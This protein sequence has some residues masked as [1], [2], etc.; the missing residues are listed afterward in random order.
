M[1]LTELQVP[2]QIAQRHQHNVMQLKRDISAAT[3]KIHRIERTLSRGMQIDFT[4]TDVVTLT[5]VV[6][7]NLFCF[8]IFFYS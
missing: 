5:L 7:A 6:I 4:K 8:Q 1:P 2:F 3:I